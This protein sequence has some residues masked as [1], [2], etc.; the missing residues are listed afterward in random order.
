MGN[1]QAKNRWFVIVALVLLVVII[2]GVVAWSRG[3][4]RMQG[5]GNI[6]QAVA[7]EAA[8]RD[9]MDLGK[10]GDGS[11]RQ[12]DEEDKDDA[13]RDD[14]SVDG[15]K[16]RVPAVG[17]VDV[18]GE[19]D[20]RDDD[21]GGLGED[22]QADDRGDGRSSI[23]SDGVP[24]QREDQAGDSGH[25]P[26][27]GESGEAKSPQDVADGTTADSQDSQE[28]PAVTAIRTRY[29]A[30]L[31]TLEASCED[32]AKALIRQIAEGMAAESELDLA[33]LR[34]EYL[35]IVRDAERSCDVQYAKIVADAEA[36]YAAL[37]AD[38]TDV[39]SR[40]DERYEAAKDRL[41]MQALFELMD[42]MQDMQATNDG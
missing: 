30:Q 3:D 20:D 18:D 21:R 17:G 28:D 12:T 24:R 25:G 6:D 40:W 10:S 26:S 41:Q 8:D 34:D 7:G 5:E 35:P 1:S 27:S 42:L 9:G 32:E 13:R 4:I 29:E 38:G 31:Q 14:D 15:H 11:L 33:T 36:D 39:L 23:G 16:G 2:G 37:G 19:A 22:G